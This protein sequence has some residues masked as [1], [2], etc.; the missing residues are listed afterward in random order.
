MYVIG[1]TGGIGAGKSMVSR[2]L[3]DLGAKVVDADKIAR[4]IVKP[5]EPAL[6]ELVNEFGK[7]ILTGQG[8]LDRQK[9]SQMVFG[10]NQKLE[11]LNKITHKYIV[12]RIINLVEKEKRDKRFDIIVLDVPIPVKK[13]FLDIADEIWV[14]T[15]DKETRIERIIKRSGFTREEAEKRIASLP[16][17]EEY[18]EIADEVIE[19]NSSLEELEKKVA[20]LYVKVA[21][22]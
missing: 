13:G 2:I 21:S 14:V 22:R 11:K 8:E 17:D 16:G 3:V 6:M 15:A 4:D 5:G 12:E 7:E 1:V 9:L 10:D 19:N 20:K 18:L